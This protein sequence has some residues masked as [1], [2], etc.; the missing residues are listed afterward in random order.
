MENFKIEI[1]S[2]KWQMD[3][4]WGTIT[5]IAHRSGVKHIELCFSP[6]DIYSLQ[7]FKPMNLTILGPNAEV[8]SW[9]QLE[10]WVEG[11]VRRHSITEFGMSLQALLIGQLRNIGYAVEGDEPKA[12][13]E[14]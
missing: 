14:A 12:F 7:A 5:I 4:D 11:F 13:D 3:T 6:K 1:T 10:H 8:P 9:E 2:D